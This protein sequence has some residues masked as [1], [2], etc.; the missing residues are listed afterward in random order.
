MLLSRRLSGLKKRQRNYYSGKK[1]RHTLKTQVVVNKLTTEIVCICIREGKTQDFRIF[2]ESG[3]MVNP[4]VL[5]AAE[6]DTNL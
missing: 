3:I 1:K 5:I 4:E 6:F 2:K